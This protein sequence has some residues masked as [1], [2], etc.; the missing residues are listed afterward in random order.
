MFKITKRCRQNYFRCTYSNYTH[1]HPHRIGVVISDHVALVT[2]H[3]RGYPELQKAKQTVWHI[4]VYNN[5]RFVVIHSA[6]K[7]IKQM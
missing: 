1:T 2:N 7:T 4:H 3:G 5:D 6:D